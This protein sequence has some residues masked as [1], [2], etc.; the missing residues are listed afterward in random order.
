MPASVIFR[1]ALTTVCSEDRGIRR[2]FA[3][4]VVLIATSLALGVT[5]C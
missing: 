5:E 1:R 2:A 4:K 3:A